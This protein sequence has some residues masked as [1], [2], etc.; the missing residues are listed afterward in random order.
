MKNPVLQV[1]INKRYQDFSL[2]CRATFESGITAVFGRS[3]SG[4]TTL[5]NCIA[6]LVS[7]D[8]GLIRISNQTVYSSD[9]GIDFPPETRRCGYMLQQGALFPHMNVMRNIYYGYGLT[10]EKYRSIDPKQLIEILD[11]TSIVDRKVGNLS[12]GEKQR[13]A[14]ARALA[15]SPQL[16]LLDEPLSSLD[17]GFKSVIIKYLRDIW[18]ELGTPIVYVSHSTSE[19]I[20]LAEHILILSSGRM[21]SRGKPLDVLATIVG[22]P[23]NDKNS[24]NLLEAQVIS[25]GSVDVMSRVRIGDKIFSMSNLDLEVGQNVVVSLAPREI[26]IALDPLPKISAQNVVFAR[27]DAIRPNG[28]NVLVEM[29]IGT[30][31]IA[32]ITGSALKDLELWEGQDVYIIVTSTSIIPLPENFDF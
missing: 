24:Q 31:V 13:V 6:G 14:L 18:V 28:P 17:I 5:L 11:L 7:P 25:Q 29:D 23:S 26:I 27:I 2:E 22:I 19:V 12:G 10:K 16:L 3:G 4:K 8:S 1:Q 21:I 30:K 20:E 15:T 9:D 32:E